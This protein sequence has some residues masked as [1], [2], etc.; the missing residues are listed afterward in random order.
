MEEEKANNDPSEYDGD[1]YPEDRKDKRNAY[2]KQHI[3]RDY[4]EEAKDRNSR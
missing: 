2:H 1:V 3:E 4:I